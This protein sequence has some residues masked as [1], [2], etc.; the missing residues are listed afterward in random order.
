MLAA[1]VLSNASVL[2]YGTLEEAAMKHVK[3][4][5]ELVDRFGRILD[6]FPEVQRRQMF[7]Y[8]AAFIGGNMVTG[9]HETR[10]VVR[11]GDEGLAELRAAGGTTFEPMA[12]RPMKAFAV[13]PD[14]VLDYDDAVARWVERAITHGMSMPAK[15]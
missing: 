15:K 4:P 11:L 13:L 2:P 1:D 14:A 9:L 12:G 8:P 6:R 3:A 10:W 7:G 5:P